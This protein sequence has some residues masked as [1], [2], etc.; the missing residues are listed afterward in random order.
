MRAA[1]VSGRFQNVGEAFF[2][3]EF[4]WWVESDI[5]GVKDTLIITFNRLIWKSNTDNLIKKVWL[6]SDIG[7]DQMRMRFWKIEYSR[8]FG[9]A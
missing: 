8:D 1:K 3:E 6:K 9:F 7:L 4:L 5:W 2:T